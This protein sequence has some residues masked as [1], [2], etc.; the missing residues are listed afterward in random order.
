ALA[1]QAQ[2]RLQAGD[3]VGAAQSLAQL[4]AVLSSASSSSDAATACSQVTTAQAAVT[5]AKQR[6]VSDRTA[7]VAAEQKKDVDAA[8][9]RV[10]V[11]NAEQAEIAA[12]NTLNSASSDPPFYIEEQRAVVA[13]A[14][15][16]VQTARKDVEDTVLR[17]RS[18]GTVSAINGVVGEFLTPSTGTTALAPGS[19][20]AIPGTGSAG[21][22]GA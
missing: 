15:V 16:M 7:L 18:E 10:A 19:K 5:A 20:A 12:Q 3:V 8:A 6:V 14:R 2:Q 17:S 11:A 21:A 4:S 22:A 9:G 1:H 13:G